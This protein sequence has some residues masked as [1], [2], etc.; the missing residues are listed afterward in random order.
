MKKIITKISVLGL[1]A[2]IAVLAFF[3]LNVSALELKEGTDYSVVSQEKSEEK[4]VIEFFS[5]YCPH[6][7]N[8]EQQEKIPQEIIKNLPETSKFKQYH[9]SALGPQ[10]EMLTRAWSVA[11]LLKKEDLIKRDLFEATQSYEINTLDD[12][13]AIFE[14]NGINSDTFDSAYGSLAVTALVNEQN[15][16]AEKF[17]INSVPSIIVSKQYKIETGAFNNIKTNDDYKQRYVDLVLEL[18]K[19]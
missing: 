12:I 14:K 5:F 6:C 13:K 2:F 9:F 8:F 15:A 18:L 17:K 7:K 11:I 10:G 3:S 16:L 4:N 1:S 19:K